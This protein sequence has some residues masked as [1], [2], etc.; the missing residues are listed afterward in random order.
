VRRPPV[1]PD[2]SAQCLDR[3]PGGQGSCIRRAD[4]VFTTFL[5]SAVCGTPHQRSGAPGVSMRRLSG[6]VRRSVDES[7]CGRGEVVRQRF[8]DL[9]TDGEQDE[10]GGRHRQAEELQKLA[11]PGL[12]SRPGHR[13]VIRGSSRARCVAHGVSCLQPGSPVTPRP[14]GNCRV[15]PRRLAGARRADSRRVRDGLDG[16]R[17]RRTG[18]KPGG[19]S[20][21]GSRG[22]VRAAVRCG[23]TTGGKGRGA[24]GRRRPAA[25]AVGD[26]GSAPVRQWS[27]GLGGQAWA[28]RSR[29]VGI[30]ASRYSTTVQGT[31]GTVAWTAPDSMR[32]MILRAPVRVSM[33]NGRL[34]P[35]DSLIG[36]S[37]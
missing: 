8:G 19:D 13:P 3:L 28:F 1:R 34:S 2:T 30:R 27:P 35:R 24:E 12:A 31:R 17:S 20:G 33:R 6:R 15:H 36:V 37:M 21:T 26:G 32:F 29:R 23:C 16:L 9:R 4:G 7:G 22:G 14:S 25:G 10:G 11:L 18:R 5:S